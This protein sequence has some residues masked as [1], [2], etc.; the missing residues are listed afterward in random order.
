M[1]PPGLRRKRSSR[2]QDL[3]L[4]APEDTVRVVHVQDQFMT[5]MV[6]D[7][8][9][10][11]LLSAIIGHE[12]SD[13]YIDVTKKYK[14]DIVFLVMWTLSH[15]GSMLALTGM[16]SKLWVWSALAGFPAIV[17]LA[18]FSNRHIAHHLLHNF[19]VVYLIFVSTAWAITTAD[20]F[21][22]DDRLVWVSLYWSSVVF[23]VFYDAAA[24]AFQKIAK[25]AISL[26]ILTEILIIAFMHFDVFVDMHGRMVS[27]GGTLTFNTIMFARS[28][29]QTCV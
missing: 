7:A 22:H 16:V 1:A 27:V 25:F 18:V 13:A 15:L 12:W 6:L 11:N 14:L 19:E 9:A 2:T 10:D 17:Q 8:R 20:I 29:P 4:L 23:V 5:A 21:N 28:A 26:S 24:P 3:G